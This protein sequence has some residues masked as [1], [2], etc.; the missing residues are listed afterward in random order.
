MLKQFY[1][2]TNVFSKDDTV[3]KLRVENSWGD[4]RHEKGYLVM[5]AAW[6]REFVFEVVVDKSALP[7]AVSKAIEEAEKEEP[8]VLPA[9]DPMGALA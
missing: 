9:W 8:I 4:D 5:T 3:T 2:L 7:E 1:E 6:F